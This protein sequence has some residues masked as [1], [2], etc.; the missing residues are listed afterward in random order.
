MGIYSSIFTKSSDC[1]EQRCRVSDE[2]N[3]PHYR[4]QGADMTR[5]PFDEMTVQE[6]V[7]RFDGSQRLLGL[8]G[9]S[10]DD[11]AM[12]ADVAG[13]R[14][15]P[16]GLLLAV[17]AAAGTSAPDEDDV[18]S[19]R[20][21][22]QGTVVDYVL[23]KYHEPL[24]REFPRLAELLGGAVSSSD[25]NEKKTLSN[26][27]ATF[28]VLR[29]Q[30]ELHMAI[31]ERLLF[32]ALCR[33][34]DSASHGEAGGGDD[35]VDSPAVAI[36]EME[37]EHEV[38]DHAFS[39]MRQATDDYSVPPG[40]PDVVGAVYEALAQLEAALREHAHVE[41]DLLWPGEWIEAPRAAMGETA[42]GAYVS[43]DSEGLAK[44]RLICPQTNEPC[45]DQVA[46]ACDRYWLCLGEAMHDKW[47]EAH[48]DLAGTT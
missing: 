46:C 5:M 34:A 10:A 11:Q 41:D 16:P 27:Q 18:E 29:M 3:R 15:W 48:P 25:G 38:I 1:R 39:L 24:H 47:D 20:D 21:T 17:V 6:M 45:K 32:P 2:S 22:L 43:A 35:D 33:G 31:E 8:L 19:R 9:I 23:R 44:A 13:E 12:V 37:C 4:P 36:R 42:A 7:G 26:L 28:D 30:L 14:G 40:A